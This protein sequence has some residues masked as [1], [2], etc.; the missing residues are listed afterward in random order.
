MTAPLQAFERPPHPPLRR[1]SSLMI[2]RIDDAKWPTLDGLVSVLARLL[3]LFSA[4]ALIGAGGF[5]I[6]RTL[7]YLVHRFHD[8]GPD[9]PASDYALVL[10]AG[11]AL[12]ACGLGVASYLYQKAT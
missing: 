4:V 6:H 11:I 10:V 1:G 7:A 8:A 9:L 2:A 5:L 3:A 12:I